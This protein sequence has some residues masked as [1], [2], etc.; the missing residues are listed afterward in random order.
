MSALGVSLLSWA[1][2]LRAGQAQADQPLQG[3]Q[4]ADDAQADDDVADQ[5]A[6]GDALAQGG[7]VQVGGQDLAAGGV[8]SEGHACRRGASTSS[9]VVLVKRPWGWRPSSDRLPVSGVYCR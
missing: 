7:A 9:R 5:A 8:D 4:Q 6:L 1:V 3:Q 2:T